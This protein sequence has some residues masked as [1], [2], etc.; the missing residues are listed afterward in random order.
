[1]VKNVLVSGGAGYIGSHTILVL[2][3]AGFDV[4]VLDNFCNS[5]PISLERVAHIT[6]RSVRL[7]EGDVRD[8]ATLDRLFSEYS[9][10]A[11]IHFAGLKSVGGSVKDPMA[12]YSNNVCGSQALLSAMERWGVFRFVF[13]SSATIYGDIQ[14]MPI[15]E[16][17]PIS[18]PA[19]TYGRTKLIVE[20]IL[21]DLAASDSRWRI[22]IMR[23]FNPVGAHPSGLIGEDP[24]GT[25]NNLLPYIAQVAVGKHSELVVFGNDYDTID[26]TGVRDYIHV[27][28]LARGHLHALGA[29]QT[30]TGAHA[31]NLGTGQ[32]YSVLEIIR[33]F[34]DAS[35]CRV[36]FRFAHRRPGDIAICYAD[37]SKAHRELGW[38]AL[39][40]IEEMMS[41]TWR[42]AQNNPN[43]YANP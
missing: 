6:G 8:T 17:S 33:A 28:D 32:G 26:G 38:Q 43:G 31:W 14:Q 9:V 29:L 40:S 24:R 25:P 5:L 36:P 15:A 30:L 2:L 11:T 7:V 35:G 20:G 22:G 37:A 1:M 4:V 34:E 39:L 21:H 42:W 23:Y 10:D 3:E 12:Y 16:S 27:M 19:N 13:S 41:D 18:Q